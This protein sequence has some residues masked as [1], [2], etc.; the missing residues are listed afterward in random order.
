MSRNVSRLLALGHDVVAAR[1][2]VDWVENYTLIAN[3][4]TETRIMQLL[5]NQST[6]S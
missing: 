4:S 3:Q 6:E 1:E 5:A 2:S